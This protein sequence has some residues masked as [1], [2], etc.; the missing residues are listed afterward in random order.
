MATAIACSCAPF[1]LFWFVLWVALNSAP[2]ELNKTERLVSPDDSCLGQHG[3]A[4]APSREGHLAG[5]S[6]L[7]PLVLWKNKQQ[8]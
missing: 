1:M 2:T 4:P 3:A 6:S 7:Q 5:A 8:G